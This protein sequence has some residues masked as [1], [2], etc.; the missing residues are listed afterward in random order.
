M[1]RTSALVNGR[2]LAEEALD[3]VEHDMMVLLLQARV[4]DARHHGELLVGVRQQPEEFHEIVEMG[5]SVELAARD[6]HR[7]GDFLRVHERQPLAHVD[8]G[9]VRDRVVERTDGLRVFTDD[10]AVG[11]AGMIA[12]EDALDEAGVHGPSRRGGHAA[13]SLPSLRKRRASFARP[14]EGVEDEPLHAPGVFLREKGGPQGAGG[15]AVEVKRV[16]SADSPDYVRRRENVPGA[17]LDSAGDPSRL[18]GPPV[19]LAVDTPDVVAALGEVVH[20]RVSGPGLHL[21]VERGGRGHGRAVHEEH[22]VPRFFGALLPL[23]P[24]E[25]VGAVVMRPVFFARDFRLRHGYP[26]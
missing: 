17:A 5:D 2:G 24:Q 10:V 14:D 6:H 11:R 3:Q 13:E 1:H 25:Q 18:G 7:R 9:A 21:E 15:D 26:F 22:G 19:A 16:L 4:G 12:R 23:P 8:V 20:Q